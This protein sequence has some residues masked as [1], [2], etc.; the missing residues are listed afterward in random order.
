MKIIVLIFSVLVVAG[1]KSAINN[2]TT[3][4][5]NTI[6]IGAE[7]KNDTITNDKTPLV[8]RLFK[9]KNKEQSDGFLDSL[10]TC[11]RIVNEYESDEE[12][13]ETQIILDIDTVKNALRTEDTESTNSSVIVN[14]YR[15]LIINNR[16][17][18]VYSVFAGTSAF[19]SQSEFSVYDYNNGSLVTDTASTA[20][21]DVKS[22]DFIVSN[23]PD[24]IR[25][26]IT[27]ESCFFFHIVYNDKGIAECWYSCDY[28]ERKYK[29]WFRGNTICFSIKDG[30]IVRSDPYFRE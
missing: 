30:R 8:I 13:Y 11:K 22:S 25:K 6:S 17:K 9:I 12:T 23:T 3:I 18:L 4:S 26:E 5:E 24:S 7:N 14:E 21:F 2:K 29:T 20:I 10:L 16:I 27:G 28:T 15:A 19:T 1:C